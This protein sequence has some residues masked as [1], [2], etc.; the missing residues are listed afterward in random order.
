MYM[1][2]RYVW[3]RAALSKKGEQPRPCGDVGVDVLVLGCRCRC[4]GMWI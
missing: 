1:L 4:L 3:G 2:A